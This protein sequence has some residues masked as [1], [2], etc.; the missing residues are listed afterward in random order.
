MQAID[1]FDT[2]GAWCASCD[3][4][5]LDEVLPQLQVF[6]G[7]VTWQYRNGDAPG[8]AVDEFCSWMFSI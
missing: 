7:A 1:F 5:Q 4:D 2:S 8:S 3:A 6:F